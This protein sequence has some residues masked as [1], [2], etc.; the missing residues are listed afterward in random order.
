MK[1]TTYILVL[2]TIILITLF[3]WE[4]TDNLNFT[5]KINDDK[6]ANFFTSFGGVIVAIS[7]YYFYEQLIAVNIPDLYFGSTL[8]NVT[9]KESIYENKKDLNFSQIIDEKISEL[10]SYFILHNT[11][12]GTCKNITIKWIYNIEEIKKII[13]DDYQ[14]FPIFVTES[15]KL[16]FIESNGK[17]HVEIPKFYF[18]CCAPKY[19]FNEKNHI[20]LAEK[21]LGGEEL[22]PNLNVEIVFFDSRNNKKTKKFKVEIQAVNNTVDVKFKQL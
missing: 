14:Y 3:L 8:F 6:I 15:Q 1:K 12:T 19:N 16:S 20:K 2:F 13:K 9:E 18:Y 17:V 4:E 7:L 11:G 22:Q 21:L 5:Q 10:N